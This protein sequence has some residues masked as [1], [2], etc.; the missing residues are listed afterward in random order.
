MNQRPHRIRRK[1]NKGWRMPE[2]TVY[3]GRPT[4]WANPYVG[5]AEHDNHH[6]TRLFREYC[7][8]PEQAEFVARVRQV[9]R[10]KHLACWCGLDMDCHGDVLLEIANS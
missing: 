3:V 2:N 4:E 1:R 5:D 7:E 10:G 9:L 6:V 8:R